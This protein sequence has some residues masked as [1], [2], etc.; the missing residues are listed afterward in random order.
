[1]FPAAIM[2]C[3]ANVWRIA[4]H[5]RSGNPTFGND[6][7]TCLVDAKDKSA[8]F[9]AIENNNLEMVKFLVENKAYDGKPYTL[10]AVHSGPIGYGAGCIGGGTYTP[11]KYAVAAHASRSVALTGQIITDTVSP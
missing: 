1:M 11:S 2:N 7:I 8:L 6:S 10:S 3:D 4:C 5:S 9:F